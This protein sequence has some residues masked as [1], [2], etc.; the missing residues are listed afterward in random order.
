MYTRENR[1]FIAARVTI[2]DAVG[3][4]HFLFTRF[5]ALPL[6]A[7][8]P[9]LDVPSVQLVPQDTPSQGGEGSQRENLLP[10]PRHVS[11]VFFPPVEVAPRMPS[12]RRP[13]ATFNRGSSSE[14]KSSI[15]RARTRIFD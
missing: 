12:A 6:H 10:V 8:G 7:M 15:A 9:P 3:T 1:E 2:L 5:S 11:S 13:R 4:Y 14:F